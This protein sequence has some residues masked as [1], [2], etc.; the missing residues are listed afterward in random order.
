MDWSI[1]ESKSEECAQTVPNSLCVVWS[2]QVHQLFI[3]SQW[4]FHLK[5][6][7]IVRWTEKISRRGFDYLD[8]QRLGEKNR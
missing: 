4:K 3:S 2:E 7:R 5:H 1:K 8:V 6:S